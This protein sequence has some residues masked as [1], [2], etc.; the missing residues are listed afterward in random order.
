MDIVSGFWRG[1]I[2]PKGL[3]PEQVAYWEEQFAKAAQSPEWKAEMEK[4]QLEQTF[5]RA[6]ESRK[7]LEAESKEYRAILTDLGLA[8]P[9]Q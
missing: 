6:A 8:K 1:A 4:G 2:G 7:F 3:K 9:A 5:M